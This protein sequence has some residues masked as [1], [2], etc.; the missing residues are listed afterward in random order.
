MTTFAPDIPYIPRGHIVAKDMTIEE[1]METYAGGFY[2]YVEG[3]V[4]EMSPSRIEHVDLFKYLLAL[5]DTYLAFRKIGK[6][7]VQPFVMKLPE[8]PARRREPDL[9]VVLNSNLNRLE[10]TFMDGPADIVIEIVSEESFERDT[11]DK[12]LEYQTGGVPEYWMFDV[13][14]TDARFY[15]LN[16]SGVYM[17]K[18]L[19]ADKFYSTPLLPDLKLYV[20]VLWQ[21]ELPLNPDIVDAVRAMLTPDE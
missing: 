20:P 15:R 18:P 10:K 2:E 9:F 19:S 11:S 4:I 17:P 13:L 16:A 12:F 5:L 14:R 1:Y 6:L 21:E 7:V 8:F 3:Y